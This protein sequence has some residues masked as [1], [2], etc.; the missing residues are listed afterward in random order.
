MVQIKTFYSCDLQLFYTSTSTDK[1]CRPGFVVSAARTSFK[2]L[3]T[4]LEGLYPVGSTGVSPS[5]HK[6]RNTTIK[7]LNRGLHD[8]MAACQFETK[9]QLLPCQVSS[10]SSYGCV[11][12]YLRRVKVFRGR[13]M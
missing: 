7:L 9:V 6:E 13:E 4:R 5:P 3:L 2:K 8:A 11:I 12:M 10:G 1:V